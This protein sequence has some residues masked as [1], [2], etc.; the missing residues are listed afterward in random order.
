MLCDNVLSFTIFTTFNVKIK[1][2]LKFKLFEFF[3][4]FCDIESDKL[5]IFD[6]VNLFYNV[7]N[8]VVLFDEVLS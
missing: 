8:N 6:N 2:N 7:D 4:L 5:L 3:R 1:V